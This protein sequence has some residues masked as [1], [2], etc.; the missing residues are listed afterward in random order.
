MGTASPLA[1]RVAL[2]ALAAVA[3]HVVV[4]GLA[5]PEPGTHWDDHVVPTVVPLAIL[6]LAAVLVLRARAGWWR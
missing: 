5:A 2:L 3:L 4:D 6:G 1:R